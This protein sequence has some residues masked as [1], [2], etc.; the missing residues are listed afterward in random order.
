M[1]KSK[2]IVWT[3]TTIENLIFEILTCFKDYELKDNDYN[4]TV[5]EMFNVKWPYQPFS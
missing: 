4:L 3:C 5:S 1:V 2:F